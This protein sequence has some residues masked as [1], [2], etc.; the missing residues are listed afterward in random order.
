IGWAPLPPGAGW[1]AA[2]GLTWHGHA[3]SVGFGFGLASSCYTF[4]P[5]D[6]FCYRHIHRHRVPHSKAVNIYQNSTVINNVINGDN[7][8]IIN[9]GVGYTH[10]ASRVRGEIPK[11]AVQPIPAQSDK[12]VRADRL[13][14]RD[15]SLVVYKPTPVTDNG[16]RPVALRSKAGP[17]SSA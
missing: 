4:V 17:P 2:V 12:P 8:V 15:D 16:G 1:S 5:Y 6:S 9:N 14:R 10:V 3:V 13:E 7:N 11:A